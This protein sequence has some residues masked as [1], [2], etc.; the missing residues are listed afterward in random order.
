[1]IGDVADEGVVT[2]PL[3]EITVHIPVPTDG[4]FAFR[5]EEDEQSVES[6]PALAGVENGSILIVTVSEEEG[7]DAFVI[8]HTNVFVPTFIPVTAE[9]AEEGAVKVPVP[10]I[11]DHMPVPTVGMFPFND[12]EGEQIVESNP[13]NAVVVDGLTVI[14]TVS[15][16]EGQEPFVIV[17][18]NVL[19]PTLIAVIAEAGEAGVVMIPVPAITDQTPVPV[20]GIFPFN[21]EAEEHIVKSSPASATVGSGSMLIVISSVE[22]IHVPFEIVHRNVFTPTLNPVTAEAGEAGIVT[23]PVPV[24]TVHAPVPITGVFAARVAVVVQIV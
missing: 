16:E 6:N 10:A 23:V 4:I 21:D 14:E 18:T 1:V 2:V 24:I 22:E 20:A 8:V 11:T 7:Q 15:T 13:A 12:D 3:P 5:E 9:V 19:M 17:H